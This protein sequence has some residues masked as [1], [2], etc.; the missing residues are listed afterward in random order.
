MLLKAYNIPLRTL[1]NLGT[2]NTHYMDEHA[3]DI[4]FHY[5]GVNAV[6][7]HAYPELEHVKEQCAEFLLNL[8]NAKNSDDF[9]YFTTSGSSESVLLAMLVL[10]TQSQQLN[11]K[12]MSKPNI[13][14][15][16]NSHV[17]WHK[18]AKY[19]GVELR[20][21][22]LSEATLILDNSQVISLIDVDTIGICCTLGAPI[23][24]L[25]DDVLDLDTKLK[26][27]HRET[28]QF[29]PIHV[30]AASGGFVVPFINPEY[31]FDFRL[32][33]VFSM[34]ISSHK[35]GLVYPSLGWLL[36]RQTPCLQELLH[37]SDY[38]G[39]PVKQFSVQFSHSA[40][41]LMAQYYY[42][43]TLGHEGY[44][45]IILKLF[46]CAAQLKQALI[47]TQKNIQFIENGRT[48]LPGVV[49]SMNEVDMDQL[50]QKLKESNWSLPVYSLPKITPLS[51]ARIVIRH[52]YNDSFIDDLVSDMQLCTI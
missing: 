6:D 14:I 47:Q 10:K 42:I 25:C 35:Y 40:S 15:G 2:F 39:V 30:D 29:I 37:E 16:A 17:A 28:G 21:A 20:I 18:A 43:Q 45:K 41:H 23:T 12:H 32:K 4:F 33:H 1:R 3:R 31:Q 19:L 48:S 22:A 27:H 52:G 9:S 11:Q 36:I 13:I 44:K 26:Q 24:L 38:L 7:S 51:V 5:A 49:F 34:N 50:S 8:V 46:D